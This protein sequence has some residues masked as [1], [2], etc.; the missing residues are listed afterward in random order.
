VFSEVLGISVDSWSYFFEVNLLCNI[1][2]AG[3]FN[4][5][6]SLEGWESKLINHIGLTCSTQILVS[7][8]NINS[9]LLE[10]CLHLAE[11]LSECVGELLYLL[12]SFVVV[13]VHVWNELENTLNIQSLQGCL[14]WIFRV[15]FYSLV[16]SRIMSVVH[17][18]PRLEKQ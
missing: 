18:D 13:E 15:E 17:D 3:T 11:L 16:L 12:L 1:V 14:N 8:F 4:H 5:Q 10:P 7:T 2:E 9:L 6:Y